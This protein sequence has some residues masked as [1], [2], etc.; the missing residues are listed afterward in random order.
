M[1]Q[2]ALLKP[3]SDFMMYTRGS[4]DEYNDFAKVTGDSGWSWKNLQKY[5]KR[6]ERWTLPADNHN[7]TGQFD[8]SVHSFNGINSVS[9]PGF[10]KFPAA[11]DD[12]VINAS[13]QLSGDYK[14]NLDYSSG[15]PLGIGTRHRHFMNKH[16]C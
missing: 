12:R 7:I 15:N 2:N 14:F 8:P 1:A 3:N 16:G 10:L 13:H 4:R 6:N 9:L 11:I 5:F